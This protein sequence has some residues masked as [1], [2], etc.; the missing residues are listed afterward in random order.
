MKIGQVDY[1][2]CQE[3]C[4]RKA[5]R[6][7][8]STDSVRR[9]FLL[10]AKPRYGKCLTSYAIAKNLDARKVLI[11]CVES[12]VL[13]SWHDDAGKIGC[14]QFTAYPR[15]SK[16]RDTDDFYS[17]ID[18][19]IN[20]DK[21]TAVFITKK[22][23][24]QAH[25]SRKWESKASLI[26][27]EIQWD[28]VVLDECHKAIDSPGTA[29]DL[30]ALHT[31]DRWLHLTGTPLKI[32]NQYNE[33]N[34]YV[35][36][37]I[38][39]QKLKESGD[40]SAS[41]AP[42]I[43]YQGLNYDGRI[44]KTTAIDLIF[45]DSSYQD[46]RTKSSRLI[47]GII[48][49]NRGRMLPNLSMDSYFSTIMV[50]LPTIYDCNVFADLMRQ[51][52]VASTYHVIVAPNYTTRNP[53]EDINESIR[54][55]HK[56][57]IITCSKLLMGVTIRSLTA[58]YWLKNSKAPLEYVQGAFRAGSPALLRHRWKDKFFIIDFCGTRQIVRNLAATIAA[59][60]A[61]SNLCYDKAVK[62]AVN[63]FKTYYP[64]LKTDL[65]LTSTGT[66]SYETS[67]V[68]VDVLRR[69]VR[70]NWPYFEVEAR[71]ETIDSRNSVT[72]EIPRE[73]AIENS[74]EDIL[75]GVD[76]V[77]TVRREISL[78]ELIGYGLKM[79]RDQDGWNH[80][81]SSVVYLSGGSYYSDSYFIPILLYKI[82]GSIIRIRGPCKL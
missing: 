77:E 76:T 70:D 9:D 18:D 52:D 45:H 8:R 17:K 35:F 16:P 72:D 43:V 51:H 26:F 81:L 62:R 75:P 65:K 32:L 40:A 11:V 71:H 2:S 3:E 23:L 34:K 31:K 74:S 1:R 37:Y 24:E 80:G 15:S 46:Y 13:Q 57:C 39:E 64:V 27:D 54:Q 42:S 82:N 36:D 55:G 67:M 12:S 20:E 19:A 60:E 41:T 73:K 49:S 7:F 59:F 33:D 66:W 56:T 14:Y 21:P 28:L 4:I 79:K 6:Y 10:A 44:S 30:A 38:E 58:V 25:Q 61:N 5:V 68:S 78:R 69:Y 48:S 53:L 22:A 47:D 50:V 29:E 63:D